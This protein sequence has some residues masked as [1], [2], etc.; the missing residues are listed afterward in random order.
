MTIR[1]ERAEPVSGP[2]KKV[3]VSSARKASTELRAIPL[4]YGIHIAVSTGSA[5]VPAGLM[6]GAADARGL[7]GLLVE[8]AGGR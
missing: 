4:D 8:M 7:A 6:I 1:T 3:T 5:A 2:L